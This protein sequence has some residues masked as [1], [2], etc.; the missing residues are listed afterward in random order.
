MHALWKNR[1]ATA[2]ELY[3]IL[4]PATGWAYTTVKTFC[5]RL[6]TKKAVHAIRDGQQ[7]LYEAAMPEEQ[8]RTGALRALIEK[9]FQGATAPL[10]QFLV[11]EGNLTKEERA[12]LEAVLEKARK[13]AGDKAVKFD[14]SR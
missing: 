13:R 14:E 8:A 7:I 6:V 4:H 1:V 5:D 2:R 3:E 10:L 9:A 12:Q 11:K